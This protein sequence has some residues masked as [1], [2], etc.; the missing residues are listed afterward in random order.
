MYQGAQTRL[1][2]DHAVDELL[3]EGAQVAAAE[4]ALT[5]GQAADNLVS[6]GLE[7]RVAGAG[8]HEGAGREKVSGE[9]AAEL[10]LGLFP[11][12]QRPGRRGQA[13][14]DAEVVQQA[15]D[16]EGQQI[17]LI[18]LH[19]MPERTGQQPHV[20]EIKGRGLD[21]DHRLDFVVIRSS[22]LDA[23]G[24]GH[25]Q[26][27]CQSHRRD[28]HAGPGAIAGLHWRFVLSSLRVQNRRECRYDCIPWSSTRFQRWGT[29]R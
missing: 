18:K 21:L 24:S 9:V 22:G 7:A 12:S 10:D 13:G 14:V 15:V 8:V 29:P 25:R 4:L 3:G 27:P 5:L 23:S 2:R 1:L 28:P 20:F 19:R 17:L 11:A 6:L 16:I 26:P